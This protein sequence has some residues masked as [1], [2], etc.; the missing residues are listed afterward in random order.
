MTRGLQTRRRVLN[1]LIV[2]HVTWTTAMG[3]SAWYLA[4]RWGGLE[5]VLVYFFLFLVGLQRPHEY[6]NMVRGHRVG[7]CLNGCLKVG[8]ISML[9]G[10]CIFSNLVYI[11][12]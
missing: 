8:F 3:F 5:A 6:L 7:N 10:F 2:F 12:K 1:V 9:F 4:R 11:A